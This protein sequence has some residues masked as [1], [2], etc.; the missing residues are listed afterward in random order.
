[1]FVL[2]VGRSVF[3]LVRLDVGSCLFVVPCVWG[4]GVAWLV[5][6]TGGG[7]LGIGCYCWYTVVA[8]CDD[9]W[10]DALFSST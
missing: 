5:S 9:C 8:G 1:M 3:T 10:I 6:M 4:Q 2:L 7:E